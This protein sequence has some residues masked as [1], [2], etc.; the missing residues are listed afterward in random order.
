MY[1]TGHSGQILMQFEYYGQITDYSNIKI[2]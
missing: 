2:H 1:N